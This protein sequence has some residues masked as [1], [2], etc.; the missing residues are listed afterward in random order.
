MH[1]DPVNLRDLWGLEANDPN[2]QS[3]LT[4]SII[5]MG[6]YK[7]TLSA[8]ETF[9]LLQMNSQIGKAYSEEEENVYVCTTYLEEILKNANLDVDKYL[10]GGQKVVNSIR[11]LSERK[12]S[13]MFKAT[14]GSNPSEGLYVF[15][16]DYGDGTGHTGFVEF[17]KSGNA[18]ILHNGSDGKGNQCVNIRTRDSRDFATWFDSE[19]TGNL[20]YQE[21]EKITVWQE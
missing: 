14:S 2:K 20:Y 5:K 19:S 16:Y 8:D 15:Y 1:N 11:I 21:V 9:K 13:G 18:K 17:D 10:P 4:Y 7:T 6:G 3:D 12:D